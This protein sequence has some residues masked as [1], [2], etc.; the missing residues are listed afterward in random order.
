[1]A[2]ETNRAKLASQTRKARRKTDGLFVASRYGY[3]GETSGPPRSGGMAGFDDATGAL[4][5]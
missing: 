3:A 2:G 5:A 1:M 4:G